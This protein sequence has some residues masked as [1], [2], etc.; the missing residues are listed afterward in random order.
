MVS[1]IW[2]FSFKLQNKLFQG[3]EKIVT[4]LDEIND[5]KTYPE[6]QIQGW[7]HNCHHSAVTYCC[8]I[9]NYL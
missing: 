3:L 1:S 4:Y 5:F 2:N 7:Q 8:H 9:I 6:S